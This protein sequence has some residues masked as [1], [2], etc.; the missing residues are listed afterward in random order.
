MALI[1]RAESILEAHLPDQEAESAALYYMQQASPLVQILL[2]NVQEME[3]PVAIPVKIVV[4]LAR[5]VFQF[6]FAKCKSNLN[7]PSRWKPS[8]EEIKKVGFVIAEWERHE[9]PYFQ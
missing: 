8:A 6:V 2:D 9:V 7:I 5:F 4:H 1:H 3:E